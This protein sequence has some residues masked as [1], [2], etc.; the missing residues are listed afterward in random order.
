MGWHVNDA[1]EPRYWV[2]GMPKA[3]AQPDG[4]LFVTAADNIAAHTV[5]VAQSGSGKS[6]F[7]GRLIEEILL[8]TKARCLIFDPNADF[9][10]VHEVAGEELWEEAHY[11]RTGCFGKLPHEAS[12]NRFFA[13]WIQVETEVFSSSPTLPHEKATAESEAYRRLQ[14]QL[15][16]PS[17][18]AETI[19]EEVDDISVRNQ[20]YHC[21]SF[22]NAIG[23]LLLFYPKVTLEGKGASG[24]IEPK[25]RHGLVNA[26]VGHLLE[27]RKVTFEPRDPVEQAEELWRCWQVIRS[28]SSS[29]LR[30]EREFAQRHINSQFNEQDILE[31]L[32][33]GYSDGKRTWTFDTLAG[34]LWLKQGAIGAGESDVHDWFHRARKA[35]RYVDD[36]VGRFYFGKVR[37]YLSGVIVPVHVP[38]LSRE[39]ARLTIVDLASFSDRSTRLL[40]VNW[41]LSDVWKLAE[42]AR[43]KAL[44]EPESNDTRVPTFLVLDEAHNLIPSEPR[45]R[46]ELALREQ[47]RRIA[48]E[49]RKYGIFLLIAS[50]RPDKLDPFVVSECDNKAV[51]KLDSQW[52]LGNTERALG[53]QDTEPLRKCLT[54]G[55]GRAWLVGHWVPKGEGRWMYCAA[56]RT[57]EGGRNLR[58]DHWATPTERGKVLKTLD[59]TH[60]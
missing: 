26:I 9:R 59:T 33:Y 37:E 7:L 46:A 18:K 24:S 34:H 47:F 54:A 49:G 29:L 2:E 11:D 1:L 17:L 30:A 10:A 4:E 44:K 31:R 5:I 53:L 60:P 16:W 36:E 40:A 38:P 58:A 50:Q 8:R 13:D 42:A 57:L 55:I 35:L 19:F 32:K 43:D 21:H 27:E 51:M 3:G 23:H 56:R 25:H 52:V 39:M 28:R 22:V 12:R 14:L 48:A 45:G 6:S 41:M 15:W 20:L